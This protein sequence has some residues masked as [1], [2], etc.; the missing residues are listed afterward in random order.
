MF[1][2]VGVVLDSGEAKRRGARAGTDAPP[3]PDTVSFS[4][5]SLCVVYASETA[6]HACPRDL[7]VYGVNLGM[8][9]RWGMTGPRGFSGEAA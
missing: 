6:P 3:S 4:G 1:S 8:A 9:R 5:K 7:F 2:A